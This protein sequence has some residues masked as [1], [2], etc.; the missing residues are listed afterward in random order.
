MSSRFTIL[1]VAVVTLFGCRLDDRFE[2]SK[3]VDHSTI[4][5]VLQHVAST[6][7]VRLDAGGGGAHGGLFRASMEIECEV[8]FDDAARKRFMK[9]LYDATR[10]LLAVQQATIHGWG[11][12]GDDYDLRGFSWEYSWK[13]NNGII[14]IRYY[15]G[16]TAPGHLAVFCYEHRRDAPEPP[17][18][19]GF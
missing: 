2:A 16:Q 17:P 19:K 18:A 4:S 14:R 8:Q 13:G 11:K 5:S 12:Q 7:S 3:I 9:S 6:E 10:T 15:P 1:A